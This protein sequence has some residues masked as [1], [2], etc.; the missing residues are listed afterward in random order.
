[1]KGGLGLT[2]LAIAAPAQALNPI[3]FFRGRTSG[4]ATLKVLLQSPKRLTVQSHG[5]MQKDGSLLLKQVIVEG[6]KPPRTRY[7]RMRQTG[8]GRFSGTLTDAVGPVLV[9]A[10]G[11]AV[12][13]RY[14]DKNSLAFE[15]LLTPAGPRVVN[16]RL[17][18][19]RFG[20]T[21]A[22]LDEVIRKRN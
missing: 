1:M 6:S 9:T 11:N 20:I 4:E 3:G 12:R 5:T 14:K 16:N 15:Q 19:K 21:V 22:R 8:P 2:L 18:V 17:R 7:W 13:I 10:E